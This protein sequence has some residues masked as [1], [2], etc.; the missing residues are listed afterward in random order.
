MF[1]SPSKLLG[2]TTVELPKESH[3]DLDLD[4]ASHVSNVILSLTR[5]MFVD[6]EG[7]YRISIEGMNEKEKRGGNL[8]FL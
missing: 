1:S 7:V 8:V 5:S 6:K 2:V 3:Q 4:M